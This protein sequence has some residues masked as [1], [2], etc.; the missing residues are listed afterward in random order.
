[1]DELSALYSYPNRDAIGGF[2]ASA[3]CSSTSNSP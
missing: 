2:A 3:Y 1:V